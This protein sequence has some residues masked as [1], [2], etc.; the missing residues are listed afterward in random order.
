MK[1]PTSDGSSLITM[2]QPMVMM[3]F[4]PF[5]RELTSTIG[6]GSRNRRTLETGNCFFVYFAMVKRLFISPRKPF[7]GHRSDGLVSIK[8]RGRHRNRRDHGGGELRIAVC[9]GQSWRK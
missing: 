3:L 7:D 8:R 4:R 2:C 5:Q 6:P 9:S 1:H